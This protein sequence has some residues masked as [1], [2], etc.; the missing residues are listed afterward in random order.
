MNSKVSFRIDGSEV[1]T[2]RSGYSF[3]DPL[4]GVDG[5][6]EAF[7]GEEVEI[8]RFGSSKAVSYFGCGNVDAVLP[9]DTKVTMLDGH[10]AVAR[11]YILRRKAVSGGGEARRYD[12][13]EIELIYMDGSI[14]K[15]VECHIE[16]QGLERDRAL[17]DQAEKA[18]R[19]FYTRSD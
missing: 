8:D 7:S 19:S 11:S 15:G 3:G 10:S 4:G 6:I 17:I 2:N 1:N 13:L 5:L 16:F 12:K 18:V 14:N 9:I